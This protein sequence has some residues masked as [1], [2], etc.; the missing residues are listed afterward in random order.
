MVMYRI[1]IKMLLGD[2]AK[3]IGILIGLTFASLLI[4]QQS[5]I[6]AG[7][8]ARTYGFITDTGS[9]D[10]WVMDP[11]VENVDDLKPL[12]Q[13][14]LLRVR[15][16]EG[17]EWA[18]PMFKGVLRARLP[19][20]NLQPVTV[21]GL[22]D[23]TL[24]GGPPN[25]VEGKL[26]DLRRDNAVI[27]DIREGK[28]KLLKPSDED[29]SKQVL[30]GIGDQLEINDKRAVVVGISNNTATFQSAP[31][32]Y[33]TYTRALRYA[34]A[35][36]RLLSF[37]LVGLKEGANPA[38]VAK[39]IQD[40]TGLKALTKKQFQQMSYNYYFE[41]TGIPVNFGIAVA[42]GFI[43]GVAIAGQ[44]FYNFTLDN[45]RYFG[46]LKAMG[47]N[48]RCLVVMI[49]IQ[50][51]TVGVIGYGL[52]IGIASLM[53]IVLN[54]TELAFHLSASL[55]LFSALAILVICALSAILSIQKVLR[56]E[57]SIVFRSLG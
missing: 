40:N 33:T 29:P 54:N 23:A 30:I 52:G 50:S 15:G 57:P 38:I 21:I 34:P 26:G 7:L 3:F 36:R 46:T 53:G 24:T 16:I 5:A 48:R 42:L 43:V 20:G 4:T 18:V 32:V 35:E 22:D 13:T 51:L 39:R 44:M 10:L 28:D 8:M 9:P 45:L 55:M 41:K 19:G 49:V 31:T 6:F 2:R 47:L 14:E 56:L 12:Q 27:F 17:V 1:A 37:V 11:N 25:M